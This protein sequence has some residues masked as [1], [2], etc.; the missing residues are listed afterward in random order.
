MI[1]VWFKLAYTA[2]VLVILAIWL[3][4]YG[5]RN[6]MWFSD[7][8][9]LGAVPALWLESASLASVLTVA[10]FVPELLW[11]VDLVLRLALRRRIIGLTEYMFERDRP[12]FLRLLSL[13]HVPLP[14]VLL[15]MV[16]EYGYAADIALPGATLLAAIVLPASRVFGSPEANINWSYGPGVVQQRLRPAAYV[17]GLYLGFVL[18]LFLPTDRL[19]RHF[20]PLAGT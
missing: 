16:W 20:F 15:W 9:L 2:F 1:P 8:A 10:V 19:L 6:L 17:A 12:R 7:V 5:W 3:K 4:H 13:F 11:N 18:L 14:A